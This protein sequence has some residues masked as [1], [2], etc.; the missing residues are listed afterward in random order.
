VV[1]QCVPRDAA[2]A[3][4]LFERRGYVW[5]EVGLERQQ[6]DRVA[7]SRQPFEVRDDLAVDQRVGQRQVADVES[8]QGRVHSGKG[9]RL[10][11]TYVINLPRSTE[12]REFQEEQLARLGL[13]HE[14]VPGVD[15]RKLDPSDNPLP[16]GIVG[17]ALGNINAY[18]KIVEDGEPAGVVLEDDAAL[19]DNINEVVDL[20][21]PHLEGAEAVL[22][23]YRAQ[24]RT[25]L[26]EVGATDI[27]GGYRLLYAVNPRPLAATTAYI[28]TNEAAARLSEFLLPV[29]FWPDFW[30][31]FLEGGAIDR[32]RC[33]VPRPIEAQAHFKST[34]GYEEGLLARVIPD[35][36][37]GWRR[38]W[39]QRRY[40][41]FPIVSDPPMDITSLRAAGTPR[42]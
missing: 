16:P 19:P 36:V 28:V 21:A 39:F 35:R 22:L 31:A 23:H 20:V 2:P 17:C 33:V 29:R 40:S 4:I 41:D 3:Q 18:R 24:K 8:A 5:V 42:A 7:A 37:R 13:E 34:V 12:R 27:G 32:I 38:N 1:A 6:V 25:P 11:K 14:F 30:Y 10:L 26:S 9:K 15:G